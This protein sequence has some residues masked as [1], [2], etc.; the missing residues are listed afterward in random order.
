MKLNNEIEM[1]DT[2]EEWEMDREEERRESWRWWWWWWVIVTE[3]EEEE[4]YERAFCSLWLLLLLLFGVGLNTLIN[5]DEEAV[6]KFM[7]LELII[8]SPLFFLSLLYLAVSDVM[9]RIHIPSFFYQSSPLY[10]L[11][12]PF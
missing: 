10:I 4:L 8:Y 5:D 1:I 9:I 12:L 7:M 6:E 2:V 11:T 3:N